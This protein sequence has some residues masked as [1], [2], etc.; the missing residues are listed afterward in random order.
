MPQP[1]KYKNQAARQAA[2]RA[3]QGQAAREAAKQRGLPP[4]PALPAMPGTARWK[5]A[6][7]LALRLVEEVGEQMQSYFDERS[8]TW[9]ES[10]RAQDFTVRVQAIEEVREALDLLL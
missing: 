2:Y 3:R 10:E 6:L 8:Q 4:L 9:Q 1:A 7:T 5:A